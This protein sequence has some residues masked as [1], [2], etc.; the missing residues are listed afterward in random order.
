MGEG[1]APVK[2]FPHEHQSIDKGE[3]EED[4]SRGWNVGSSSKALPMH[5]LCRE[6]N[7]ETPTIMILIF[8]TILLFRIG[9]VFSPQRRL[10]EDEKY[11]LNILSEPSPLSVTKVFVGQMW[12]LLAI[13]ALPPRCHCS[14]D[15][16]CP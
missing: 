7:P 11:Q 13:V 12:H 14:K 9:S 4:K 3:W 15:Q 16:G 1:L 6:S 8:I 2:D 10:S 5:F